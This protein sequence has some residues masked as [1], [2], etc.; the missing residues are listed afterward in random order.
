MAFVVF[1]F[2]YD[3]L[4]VF[5][6][7]VEVAALHP[8]VDHVLCVGDHPPRSPALEAAGRAA[9]LGGCV[10]EVVQQ[11]RLGTLRPGKGD[12]ILSGLGAFLDGTGDRVHFYDADIRNFSPA[13]IDVAEAALDAGSDVAKHFFHRASTDAQ[14]TWHITKPGAAVLWPSS[15]FPDVRQPLGGEFALTRRAAESL[16]SSPHVRERSDWGIDTVLTFEML[17]S[18]LSVHEVFVA[19]GKDHGYYGSLGD[20]RVMLFECLDALQRLSALELPPATNHEIDEWAEVPEAVQNAVAFDVEATRPLV[21]GP[22]PVEAMSI[23][24]AHP[25]LTPAPIAAWDD[26][27][28]SGALRSLLAEFVLGDAGWEEVAFRAWVSRVLFHT[29]VN[30]PRG[31]ERA[32]RALHAAVG[33]VRRG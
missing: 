14:V 31:H 2:R 17:R 19:G 3:D 20:L 22:L 29:A 7:S 13:W 4:D 26:H 32:M 30:A 10:V 23:L 25:P 6:R 8:A 16:W 11:S 27:R 18:G 9:G 28:W 21:T 24:E 33:V 1:P 15:G 5:A 12:A